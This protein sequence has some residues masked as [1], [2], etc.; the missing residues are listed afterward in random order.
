MNP[1]KRPSYDGV[2]TKDQHPLRAKAD[3]K[4][5]GEQGILSGYGSKFWV[6]DSYAECTAP[7]A[8]SRTIAERGPDGADRIFLR[9]EH[10]ETIGVWTALREDD[11]GLHGEAFIKDDGGLGSKLR[12]HLAEPHPLNYGLSIGFRGI[13]QR[14]AT[15]DDPL[16]LSSAPGWVKQLATQDIGQ[17]TV[18]TEVKLMEIS[19]V[20]F[21]AVD[22]ALVESYRSDVD[23]LAL[24]R[25]LLGLKAGTLTPTQIG[26]LREIAAALPAAGAP[27]T[28]QADARPGAKADST[29]DDL[30]FLG[31]LTS[32]FERR[33]A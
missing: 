3:A 10:Y 14:P 29:D 33:I 11:Q 7:G 16:D 2:L 26:L 18:L 6:V 15:V 9:F 25:L 17:I 28:S 13:A 30:L 8:F 22:P 12:K 19:A 21:P 20:T 24:Q 23:E 27:A 1:A 5:V 31:L 4:T 32:E